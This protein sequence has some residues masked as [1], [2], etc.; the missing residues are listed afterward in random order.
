MIYKNN[1][2]LK[3]DIS[4]HRYS[5]TNEYMISEFGVDL[6][7]MAAIREDIN[8]TT[9]ANR[10]LKMISADVYRYIYEHVADRDLT[11]YLLAGGHPDWPD[12][13]QEALGLYAYAV[14]LSGNMF[15]LEYGLSLDSGKEIDAKDLSINIF[16]LLLKSV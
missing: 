5:I 6:N 8:P 3:Y 7:T 15:S 14:Y 2:Y 1:K 16:L 11:E 12:V 9:A 10:F 4:K 13:I